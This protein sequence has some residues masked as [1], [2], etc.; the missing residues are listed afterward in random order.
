MRS[1]S[2]STSAAVRWEYDEATGKYLR[3]QDGSE[4]NTE[5]S[6]QVQ[7][8]NVVV[9]LMDYGVNRFDGNPDM[10]AYGSNPVLIF[11]GATVREGVW[12]RFAPENGYGFYD[13]V[14]DLNPLGLLPGNT[15]VEF[16]RNEA[17]VVEVDGTVFVP[18][19]TLPAVAT[20]T[21]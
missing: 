5:D 8:D 12:L 17:G 15:W 20:T 4:N 11:S 18:E 16:P 14:D 13:N 2:N 21:P 6:G 9:M 10:Q 3:W 19:T 7:A 1:R